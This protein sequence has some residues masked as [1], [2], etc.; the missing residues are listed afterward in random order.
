LDYFIKKTAGMTD[1]TFLYF[2]LSE[3][4]TAAAWHFFT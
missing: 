1:S 3:C 4:K 2:S